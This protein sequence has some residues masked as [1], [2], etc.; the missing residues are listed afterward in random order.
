MR[1]KDASQELLDDCPRKWQPTTKAPYGVD[2]QVAVI[3]GDRMHA[4]VFPCRRDVH[5][6]VNAKSG[7]SVQIRPTHWRQWE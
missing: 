5:G 6:W 3:E 4:L 2:L 1:V 7:A